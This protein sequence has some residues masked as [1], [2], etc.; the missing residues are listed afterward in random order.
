MKI[1]R[2]REFSR[3]SLRQAMLFLLVSLL[4]ACEAPPNDAYRSVV[5]LRHQIAISPSGSFGWDCAI[6]NELRPALGC[7]KFHQ[8]LHDVRPFPEGASVVPAR[9]SVPP[10]L[11]GRPMIFETQLVGRMGHSWEP[12][13]EFF[14]A[15]A[16]PVLNLEIPL[17]GMITDKARQLR[18]LVNGIAIA[19]PRQ[20]WV[21]KEIALPKNAIL[22]T[23][24][25]QQRSRLEIPP[26]PTH[27]RVRVV[28]DQ[29]D[30]TIAEGAFAPPPADWQQ[31]TWD[32]S[33]FAGRK[34]RFV[35]ESER[36]E[37]G[38]SFPVFGSPKV[39]VRKP[40]G[41]QRNVILISLDTLRGDHVE[42]VQ[43]GIALMPSLAKVGEEGVLFEK[44]FSPYPSTSAGH[45][46]LFTSVYPVVHRV[47]FANQIAPR[48][49]TT[50]TEVFAQNGYTTGAV[51]ENAMLAAHSGF[52]RGFQSYKENKGLG[53]W[54]SAG[55]AEATFADG[56]SWLKTH[57][58]E[59]FFL[60]LH[61]Y[62]VH[63]PYKPPADVALPPLPN[64][65]SVAEK[66]LRHYQGETRHTD[67]TM[68]R[69]F[70]TLE[71]LDLSEDTVVII[72]SDHGEA[73]GEHGHVGHSWN[74]YDEFLHVP[75]IFWAPG[76]LPAGQRI[77]GQVSLLDVAP[78]IFDLVDLPSPASMA[79]NSL[80]P[81]IRGEI[82]VPP[83]SYIYAEAPKG[84]QHK[85]RVFGARNSKYKFISRD[86]VTEPLEIYDL[87]NDPGEQKNL[88]GDAKLMSLG[89][90][91][92]APYRTWN[93]ETLRRDA[94]GNLPPQ[95][96]ELDSDMQKKLKVLGYVD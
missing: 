49:L 90:A 86:F 88:V 94:A 81:L 41:K 59:I 80:A 21:T 55:E 79:G 57:A 1:S 34:V 35:F 60:F 23:G 43:D 72:T 44:A 70:E 85:G 30:K 16:P 74:L 96:R 9:V 3:R 91:A 53:R 32:V 11:V 51:T 54:E 73:F 76:Y 25:G 89:R 33:E 77:P 56:I 42:K 78:T 69:L 61:T 67:R 4:A 8:L 83:E 2:I 45:M 64:T 68:Q 65:A 7:P 27:F 14:L 95:T 92:L 36:M 20:S 28:G 19:E 84:K 50:L 22:T 71:E 38:V 18:I 58:D 12:R 40:R 47:T 29:I 48:W 5:E 62:E 39:Q 52:A 37:D 46:S 87:E 13:Q 66:K 15:A 26:P 10:E 82:K 63:S 17:E 75:L 93:D 24:L 6:N 31:K